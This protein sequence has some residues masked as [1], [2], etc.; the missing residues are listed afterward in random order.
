MFNRTAGAPEGSSWCVSYVYTM[1]DKAAG[2]RK[3][4]PLPRTAAVWRLLAHARKLGSGFRVIRM[5]QFFQREEAQRGDIG[6]MS[7]KGTDAQLI[8]GAWLGHAFLVI[9]EIPNDSVATNEGNSNTAGSREGVR[10]I[11]RQRSKRKLLAL[12]RYTGEVGR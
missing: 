3:M 10:V 11:L 6:I 5:G 12:V 9:K 1:Y 2:S 7:N 4:N 8:G